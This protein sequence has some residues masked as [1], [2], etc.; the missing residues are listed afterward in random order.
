MDHLLDGSL[1]EDEGLRNGGVVLPLGHLT[2]HV[3]FARRRRSERAFSSLRV[4]LGDQGLDDLRIHDRPAV[5]D[6][7]NRRHELLDVLDRAP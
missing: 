6:R 3:A 2:Q 7:A 5:C 4:A 1:S